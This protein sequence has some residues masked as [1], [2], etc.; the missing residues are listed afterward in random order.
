MCKGCFALDAG[1]AEPASD[2]YLSSSLDE[3][4]E[5]I[6]VIY[7]TIIIIIIIIVII[8]VL[9]PRRGVRCDRCNL[10][11]YNIQSYTILCYDIII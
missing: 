7:N 9:E 8:P 1:E 10:L 4:Y 6:G 2:G 11:Y 3:E 5:A